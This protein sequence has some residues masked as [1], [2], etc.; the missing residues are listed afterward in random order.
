M[1]LQDIKS[2]IESMMFAFGEPLSA[3]KMANVLEVSLDEVKEAMADLLEE[4][5]ED[6]KGIYIVEVNNSYQFATSKQNYEYVQRLCKYSHSK[7]LTKV[8]AEVLAIIAYK[9]PITK[10]QVDSIRGV[11]SD[12]PIQQLIDRELICVKGRLEQI[13]RPIIYGTTE[14]FLKAFGLKT[15]KEL[16]PIEE[17]V[18]SEVFL[19]GEFNESA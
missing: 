6:K 17:F 16:P 2:S 4:Y 14:S 13:G 3:K 7:G 11:K 10:F 9:Q 8:G 18:G 12:K 5:S 1:T 19:S 15:L